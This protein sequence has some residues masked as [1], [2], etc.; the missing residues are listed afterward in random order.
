MSLSVVPLENRHIEDA[1]ALVA[2]RYRALRQTVPA[3]PPRYEDAGAFLPMLQRIS[4]KNPG[5]VALDGG[6]LVGFLT[7]WQ[8]AEWKGQRMVFGP[9]WGNG[10]AGSE[11]QRIYEAMYTAM[12]AQW[13]ADGYF[14]HYVSLF[15]HDRAGVEAWQWLN[16]GHYVVDAVRDLSPVAAAPVAVPGI[17][18]RRADPGR[19]CRRPCP[20]DRPVAASAVGADLL[21]QRPL[22]G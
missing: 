1:D 10:A 19:C 2:A 21:G 6:R 7:A 18:I 11:T 12:S 22:Y 4:S 8:V 14:N 15:A 13:V 17:E 5:V 9:E 3:T 20:V 16:F